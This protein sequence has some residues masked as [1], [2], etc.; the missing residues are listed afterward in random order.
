L[1][2]N[3]D[4]SLGAGWIIL[5]VIGSVTTGVFVWVYIK[6]EVSIKHVTPSI[7]RLNPLLFLLVL[8]VFSIEDR[9]AVAVL[10]HYRILHT[11]LFSDAGNTDE[12]FIS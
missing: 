8:L 7:A 10:R 6:L 9:T 5:I 12:D 4:E 2:T 3:D 11:N 1:P